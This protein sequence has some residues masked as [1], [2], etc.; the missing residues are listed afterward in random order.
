ML[1][2]V[3][4]N[5]IVI[6]VLY[7]MFNFIFENYKILIIWKKVII[8]FILKDLNFDYRILLNYRG[9]SLFLVIFKVYSFVLNNRL[10]VYLED[11]EFLVDE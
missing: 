7:K 11:N 9:I 4:K 2:E 5:D 8:Y 1:N 6:K 3:L 10:I